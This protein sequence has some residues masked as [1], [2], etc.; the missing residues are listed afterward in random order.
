MTATRINNKFDYTLTVPAHLFPQKKQEPLNIF[1]ESQASFFS[2]F[3]MML[4]EIP[5]YLS[6]ARSLRFKDD[7]EGKNIFQQY[8]TLHKRN[9]GLPPKQ[10]KIFKKILTGSTKNFQR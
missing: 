3:F 9:F 6:T 7:A 10:E 1:A 5:S 4:R 2:R 8:K